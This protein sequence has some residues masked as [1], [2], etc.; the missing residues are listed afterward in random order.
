MLH[1]IY[2][3][4]VASKVPLDGEATFAEIAKAVGLDEDR[5]TR[6][7]R[8]AITAGVFKESRPG[9][10]AHTAMSSVLA[11]NPGASDIFGMLLDDE[12]EAC[13]H[14]VEALRKYPEP[15][16]RM[17]E[18]PF[19]LAH[20]ANKP[21]YEWVS[22]DIRR[23]ERFQRAMKANDIKGP[24]SSE[25]LTHGYDWDA[26]NAHVFVDIGGSFGHS[27]MRVAKGS[28]IP[29]FIVQN[30][31]ADEMNHAKEMLPAEFKGRIEF[32]EHDFFK[33]Q[34]VKDADVYFLR[35]ILHNWPDE[36]C[37]AILKNLVPAMKKG[38]RIILSE[39]ILP[40]P[41]TV[42]NRLDREFR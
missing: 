2:T 31:S 11:S 4:D 42:R 35:W 16:N 21:Y 22:T 7:I 30:F 20:N 19:A 24:F 41:N 18:T 10:V 26:L 38:A 28:K 29:K 27:S 23:M 25:C 14:S 15:K 34:S 5:M 8:L 3:L 36:Q 32:Q 39:V 13:G 17:I 9:F 33:P 12:I 1:S 6:I 37:I 40:E